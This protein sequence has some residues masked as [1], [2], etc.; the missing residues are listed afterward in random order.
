MTCE[1]TLVSLKANG[2][3]PGNM[4]LCL[5]VARLT[6]SMEYKIVQ[7]ERIKCGRGSTKNVMNMKELTVNVSHGDFLGFRYNSNSGG[8]NC[9]LP[10]HVNNT[11]EEV[12]HSANTEGR[13]M[14]MNTTIS[15]ISFIF[16]A[17]IIGMM[18]P[19]NLC[20]CVMCSKLTIIVV[21]TFHPLRFMACPSIYVTYTH[22][23]ESLKPY[24]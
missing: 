15:N 18:M 3:C 6:D 11:N 24:N 17:T 9:F 1:G 21:L 7:N 8:G 14:Q 23:S 2:N 10:D 4:S 12:M 5:I 16:T 20:G 22:C 19:D 13:K